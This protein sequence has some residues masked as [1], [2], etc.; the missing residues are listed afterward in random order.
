MTNRSG[1]AQP[2]DLINDK[3]LVG[4]ANSALFLQNFGDIESELNTY[5]HKYSLSIADISINTSCHNIIQEVLSVVNNVI[6]SQF[7]RKLGEKRTVFELE[8]RQF[9]YMYQVYCNGDC[10]E[11]VLPRCESFL[12]KF[13]LKFSDFIVTNVEAVQCIVNMLEKIITRLFEVKCFNRIDKH[14]REK[15]D[16]LK[17]LKKYFEEKGNSRKNDDLFPISYS[18]STTVSFSDIIGAG[19]EGGD[20]ISDISS[21]GEEDVSSTQSVNQTVISEKSIEKCV[22]ECISHIEQLSEEIKGGSFV[23]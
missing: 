22:K 4:M 10:R 9:M 13:R 3:G 7:Q 15:G 6:E 23:N 18:Q 5:L 19:E 20:V 21:V 2:L 17:L 11:S 8:L 1:F 12:E 16:K 14:Y